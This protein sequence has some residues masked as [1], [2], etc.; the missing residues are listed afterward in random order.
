MHALRR[1][2]LAALIAVA[3]T[4]AAALAA[5][6][7]LSRSDPDGPTP[8]SAPD[9]NLAPPG[10]PTDAVIR[11][12]QRLV[13]AQ[14]GSPDAWAALAG[15]YLQKVRETGDP[16]YYAR[17]QAALD[18]GARTGGGP[19]ERLLAAQGTLALARHD[20]QH[21]LALGRAA[22][23]A[24]PASNVSFPVIVDALVELGR[25]DEAG[26]ELQ[27]FVDRKPGPASYA[28]A[29]YFRELHGDLDGAA[30][31]MR[32]AISSSGATGE[33]TAY[34]QTLL[35]TL[36]FNRGRLAAAAGAYRASLRSFPGSVAARA[37]LA[38]VDAARGRFGAAIARLQDVV[39]RLPLPEHVIALGEV[40]QAAGQDAAARQAFALVGAEQRL[41]RA[42]GV[43]TDVELA[44]FEASHGSPARA[45][46]LARRSWRTAPSVRSADALGWAL[47]RAGR[48]ADG[49]AWAQRALRLGSADPSFR[50]HAGMA[51]AAA[52]DRAAAQR[53]LQATLARTP[54]FSP[55]DAPVARRTLERL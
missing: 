7:L 27:A 38:R 44:L 8:P 16:G 33:N 14:P 13:R 5:F 24:N 4:F 52:G 54:R 39:G 1:P 40:Q 49:L 17:A 19:T 55:V 36:E 48:P 47:T 18:R 46:A 28:R 29:S 11:G 12:Y 15:A 9:V 20:F 37:G 22:R 30:A 35:G 41:L 6:A 34:L 25:Y 26:R 50:F 2:S 21:G 3:A 42:G 51:A 53:Y 43:N 31:A 10:A 32:L 45:V 23:Q